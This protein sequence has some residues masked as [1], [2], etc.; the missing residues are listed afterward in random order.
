MLITE[1]ATPLDVAIETQEKD[2]I[3]AGLFNILEAIIFLHERVCN[4]TLPLSYYYGSL[5]KQIF[6][7]LYFGY[8]FYVL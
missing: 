1:D 6:L 5:F 3:F 7:T 8:F 4:F 2:E